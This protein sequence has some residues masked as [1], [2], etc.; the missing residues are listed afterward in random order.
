MPDRFVT[1]EWSQEGT[2]RGDGSLSWNLSC[3]YCL[4]MQIPIEMKGKGE[5]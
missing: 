3:R 5:T 2:G 1:S 4:K